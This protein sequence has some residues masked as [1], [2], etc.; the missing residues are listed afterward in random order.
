[1]YNKYTVIISNIFF[2]TLYNVSHFV[3]SM[4][5]QVQ[6]IMKPVITCN[7]RPLWPVGLYAEALHST[8]DLPANTI[9]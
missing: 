9:K 4:T 6:N 3:H 2:F 1:M 5:T 7:V 8:V